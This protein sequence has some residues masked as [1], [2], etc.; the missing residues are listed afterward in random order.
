[1]PSMTDFV[2]LMMETQQNVWWKQCSES[3]KVAKDLVS[4]SLCH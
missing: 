3:I 2:V 1:M 4:V